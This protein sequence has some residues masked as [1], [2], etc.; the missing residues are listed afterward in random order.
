MFD[1]I[2]RSRK[3]VDWIYAHESIKYSYALHLR[4]TELYVSN[5]QCSCSLL[6]MLLLIFSV[7]QFGFMLPEKFIWPTSEETLNFVDYLAKFMIKHTKSSSNSYFFLSLPFVTHSFIPSCRTI[8]GHESH[9]R[10][11]YTASVIFLSNFYN[12]YSS[13]LCVSRI[14]LAFIVNS[15]FCSIV[16]IL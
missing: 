5:N 14:F 7:F 3:I 4:D 12:N 10:F 15:D 8:F 16:L 2:H 11:F 6:L 13:L 9:F 1:I